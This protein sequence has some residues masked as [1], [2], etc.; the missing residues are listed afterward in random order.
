[1]FADEIRRAVE[2]AARV[3]L[4]D[5]AALLWRAYGQGQVTE[6]E[7]EEIS[8]RIEERKA[9][10]A[11]APPAAPKVGSRPRT[12]AS[13]ERRRRWASSGRLPP[14]MA[15]RFTL[16][17]QAALAV[18]GAEV[19]KRGWCELAHEAVAALAGVSRS[20][21]RAALRRARALGLLSAEERRLTPWRSLTN[22]VRIISA[23]WRAWNGRQ[24]RPAGPDGLCVKTPPPSFTEVL[25]QVAKR[26]WERSQ[27][28][29]GKRMAGSSEP[30]QRSPR[31][32]GDLL[33]SG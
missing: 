25:G 12:D 17:E 21:V 11:A 19:A 23:E 32:R 26:A 10:P 15:A 4:P 8:A 3:K 27:G 20:T 6:A 1:M 31:T 22:V 28:A 33:A 29:S 9:L 16:A 5:V 18:V 14:Q 2:A 30:N 13:M 7:A 24:R